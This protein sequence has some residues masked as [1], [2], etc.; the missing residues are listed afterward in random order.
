MPVEDRIPPV[1]IVIAHNTHRRPEALIHSSLDEL[2][3]LLAG[4]GI[5]TVDRVVPRARTDGKVLGAGKLDEL[6]ARITELAPAPVLIA[7]DG[8]LEPRQHR[9]LEQSLSVEVIDRTGVILQVF[10]QRARTRLAKIEVE[11]ARLSYEAPRLREDTAGDDRMGGG[12]RG[13]RGHTNVELQKQAMRE[14]R[15]VLE[16]ELQRLRRT[17]LQQMQRRRDLARVA[18]VGYT[19][20]GKSSLL[21]AL[22]GADVVVQDALFATLDPT[23]RRLH[24]ETTPPILI[25]DTVGFV[26]DLP[27]DLVASFRSTLDEA[28]EADL[29]LVIVDASDPD[30][31]EQLRITHETLGAIGVEG[32]RRVVFN[33]ID[34][35][36]AAA[37]ESLQL[38]RPDALL[39]SA[40][41]P[42]AVARLYEQIVTVFAGD[43][44]EQVLIVPFEQGRLLAE[45]R[46]QAQVIDERYDGRGAVLAVRAKGN[47]LARW[48]A[49]LTPS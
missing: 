17:R 7:V 5:Q 42:D 3:R 20:A 26:R 19:N 28:R 21:R 8:G 22:T 46:A 38:D 18:L 12:G 36:D 31:P 43:D 6:M 14:R 32:T 48:R 10:E 30:W 2:S 11:L 44:E 4:L 9:E 40:H 49:R 13:E 15:A 33:K 25:S 23:V 24:P 41:D 16:R 35:L 29:L 27:H 47:V 1:A 37:R 34:R 39:L 45:I